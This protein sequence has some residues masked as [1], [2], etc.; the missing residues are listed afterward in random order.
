MWFPNSGGQIIPGEVL[1][2]S[3]ILFWS[4]YMKQC[5]HAA[6][7]AY[8]SGRHQR[9]DPCAAWAACAD[10]ANDMRW[11]T[12]RAR[13]HYACALAWLQHV[14]AADAAG[15]MPPA[16]I[17]MYRMRACFGVLWVLRAHCECS[18]R[19]AILVK[20]WFSRNLVALL[21]FYLLQ[22]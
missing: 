11:R 16:T 3:E 15:G 21:N 5:R 13:A 19:A 10:A 7:A 2:K 18:L 4:T 1:A 12:M 14:A 20:V 9:L 6:Y 8:P 22:F 17:N